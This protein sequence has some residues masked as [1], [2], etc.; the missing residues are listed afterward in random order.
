VGE[1]DRFMQ[2]ARD[3]RKHHLE[4]STNCR[5]LTLDQLEHDFGWN[6][7]RIAHDFRLAA[8]NGCRNCGRPFRNMRY[9]L[10][11]MSLDMLDPE[12]LPHYVTNTMVLCMLCN[13]RKSR[14]QP[15]A[16]EAEEQ[17]RQRQLAMFE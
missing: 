1:R 12:R 8:Q 5:G 16:W 15:G 6:L 9:G 4:R 7:P 3:T 17:R 13:R 14:K 2:K 11:D 10:H